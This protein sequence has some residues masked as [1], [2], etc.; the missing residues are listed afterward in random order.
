MQEEDFYYGEGGHSP[1]SRPPKAGS[2]HCMAVAQATII[3]G[4]SQGRNI[5]LLKISAFDNCCLTSRRA[6]IHHL[7]QWGSR[8]R[9]AFGVFLGGPS[10]NYGLVL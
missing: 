2:R 7:S 5:E 9:C 1:C 6:Q 8:C 4:A 10:S 3:P